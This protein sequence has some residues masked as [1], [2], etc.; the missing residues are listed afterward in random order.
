[1]FDDDLPPWGI[2]DNKIK[3]KVPE[4]EKIVWHKNW[5]SNMLPFD[6]PLIYEGISYPAVENFY[7]AMKLPR[8]RQD[9]RAEIAGMTPQKS[10]TNIR[11]EKYTWDSAWNKE[12]SLKV[13]E[14]ALRHKFFPG[15]SWHS[16]LM[17]TG[18]EEIVEWNNWGDR[19]WGKELSDKKGENYLGLLLEHIR[20]EYRET[21]VVNKNHGMDGIAVMRGSL[22]GNPYTHIKDKKTLAEFVVET[23]EESLEMFEIYFL[24]RVK[25]D[26][27]FRSAV[28]KLKNETLKCCCVPLKCH[29]EIIRDWLFKQNSFKIE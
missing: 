27:A 19:F 10:K 21:K 3:L 23:R 24:K 18:I 5:F 29:A 25:E 20:E 1:M 12:K 13:M 9:L 28:L 7:Q 8:D 2:G 6:E 16:R 11:K 22:F 4:Q 26:R 14:F 17:A 15:T